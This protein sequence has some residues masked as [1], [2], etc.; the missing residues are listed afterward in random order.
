MSLPHLLKYW[1]ENTMQSWPIWISLCSYNGRVYFRLKR[2][3]VGTPKD[4]IRCQ[5]IAQE[6]LIA[7]M[8]LLTKF[9]P[10]KS[11]W[12]WVQ[13]NATCLL[14]LMT[15]NWWW[16]YLYSR[17]N[18]VLMAKAAVLLTKPISTWILLICERDICL[19]KSPKPQNLL[20]TS[21]HLLEDHGTFILE[22][23][24][25]FHHSYL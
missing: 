8:Y 17:P 9:P 4:V 21:L 24:L 14:P 6:V 1:A 3:D 2:P 7:T 13:R 12:K 11:S 25:T 23:V 10:E 15:G 5:K 22:Q 18:C 16:V 20:N 19:L